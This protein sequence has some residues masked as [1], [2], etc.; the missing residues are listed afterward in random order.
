[1]IA[2]S[3]LNCFYQNIKNSDN[4]KSNVYLVF[5][6]NTLQTLRIKMFLKPT[7]SIVV[8]LLDRGLALS[9]SAEGQL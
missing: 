8:L 3:H 7:K 5:C 6:N 1:M 4:T 9:G 2:L